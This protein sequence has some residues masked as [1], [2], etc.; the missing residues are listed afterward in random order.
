MFR[1]R[2]LGLRPWLDPLEARCLLSGS[3]FAQAAG[4]TPAEVTAAY[5]LSSPTIRTPSGSIVENGSGETIALI[6]LYHDPNL[7]SDVQTFDQRFGLPDPTITV[8]NQA[9]SQT[10]NDWAVEESLD[11][12]WAHAIAP[13]AN[14]LVVEALPT[15]SNAQE[16][17]D[18]MTA[19]NTAS[20][21][22]GVVAVSMSWG[23]NE[24]PGETSSDFSFTTPGITYIAASGDTSS[25]DYPAA[26]PN[27]LA[28]GGTTLNLDSSGNYLSESAWSDSGGGYSVYEPE[29]NYQRSVQQTGQRSTPDVAFVGDPDTGVAV[30]ETPPMSQG[31]D[32]ATSQGSWQLVGGTSLGAPAWAGI[33]AIV[34]QGRFLT[35]KTSLSG[36][37]QALPSL[38]STTASLFHSVAATQS[39]SSSTNGGGST[40]GGFGGSQSPFGAS[41]TDA[42]TANTQTGLGTPNGSSLIDD[43]VASTISSLPFASIPVPAQTPT[44]APAPAT[45]LPKHAR[46]H[47]HKRLAHPT[48]PAQP[49]PKVP[50]VH[51][52]VTQLSAG[53]VRLSPHRIIT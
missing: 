41:S 17:Q 7:S 53:Q 46:R 30:Y 50:H 31:G 20:R 8:D 4:L 36:G 33:I 3:G 5:G 22:P 10:N 9:G 25:V 2:R 12:E 39:G 38:Y 43:L 14:I 45:T 26:S 15:S 24:F 13:G 27:V 51:R 47:S 37:S 48:K 42:A 40:W 11:V 29:P 16:F 28:V 52:L 34:D 21:T 18:L 44:P 6:E 32:Q 49:H 19:V 23:F 1:R 35:G